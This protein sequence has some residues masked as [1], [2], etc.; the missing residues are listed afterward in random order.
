MVLAE[1]ITNEGTMGRKKLT[2]ESVCKHTHF[3]GGERL[4]LQYH[5]TGTNRYQ[6]I[7]SP[8]LLGQVLG[9]NERTIRRE[10]KRDMVLHELGDES[11]ERW[12]YNADYAQNDAGRLSGGK[13]PDLKL[14]K[15]WSMVAADSLVRL[16]APLQAPMPLSNTLRRRAGPVGRESVRRRFIPALRQGISQAYR[17]RT[18]CSKESGASS[19]EGPPGTPG[20]PM[21]LEAS[22]RG[23]HGALSVSAVRQRVA[24]SFFSES[25]VIYFLHPHS[26]RR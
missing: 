11:F 12:G 14:G 1:H 26:A 9:K 20:Q 5:P 16:Q 15:D 23:P 6:K 10:L 7:T 21:P 24:S 25:V 8:T 2:M 18:Y 17:K 13:G 4:T 22:T 3:T 19:V